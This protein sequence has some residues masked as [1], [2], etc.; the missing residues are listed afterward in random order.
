MDV[1][2]GGIEKV[3]F[4][5]FWLSDRCFVKG[6]GFTVLGRKDNPAAV[7]AEGNSPFLSGG[8]G[9][10]LSLALVDGGD[11]NITPNNEGKFLA[12][13]A[14]RHF[15]DIVSETLELRG[16]DAVAQPDLDADLLRL[17]DSGW[18]QVNLSIVPEAE[19]T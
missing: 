8:A 12:I 18:E 13:G 3:G 14:Q 7:R 1:D 9:D 16:S 10:S 6:P 15:S 4:F 2:Y 5:L 11:V 19:S 17:E